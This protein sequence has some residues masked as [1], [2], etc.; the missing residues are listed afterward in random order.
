L[1]PILKAQQ[2]TFRLLIV[3]HPRRLSQWPTTGK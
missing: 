2:Q 1:S 3:S